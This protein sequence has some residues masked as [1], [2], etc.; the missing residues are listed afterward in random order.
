VLDVAQLVAHHRPLFICVE[1]VDDPIG[2]DQAGRVLRPAKC[3]G[4]R[5]PLVDNPEFGNIEAVFFADI[6]Y[7]CVNVGQLG[8]QVLGADPVD[9]VDPADNQWRD[10][11]LQKYAQTAQN[12]N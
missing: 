2:D 10:E 3:K 6:V 8:L 5:R 4:I 1:Q 11:I 12:G 9:P 7:E